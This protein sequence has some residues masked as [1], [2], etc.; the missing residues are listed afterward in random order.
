[1][2]KQGKITMLGIILLVLAI[3]FFFYIIDQLDQE[4][5]NTKELEKTVIK[6]EI[7]TK[8]L[9]IEEEFQRVFTWSYKSMN[10]RYSIK[11]YNET[12]EIYQQRGRERDY[13]LFASDPY[14]DYLIEDLVEKF[15]DFGKKYNLDEN[16]IP[17]FVVSFIQSLP[18]TSD[19]VTSGYDEYPRF[20]YETLYDGGG[21]CEDSAIL[22]AALLSEM[23]YGVVL[24]QF[25]DHMGLGVKCAEEV[26]GYRYEYN[27]YDYCYLETT[28]EN[29]DVGKLPEEYINEKAIVIP[30]YKRPYLD[31][32][33][34]G[35]IK[36]NYYNAYSTLN[37]TIYNLGSETAK[38]VRIYVALQTKDE[39][40]V[41]DDYTSEFL[42]IK[43]EAGYNYYV[44]NLKSPVGE[45]FRIYIVAY[46]D[47]IVSEEVVSEWVTWK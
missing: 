21:D 9:Q 31:I 44:T 16:E 10:P 30:V 27:G 14:D 47:N 36:Q 40:K 34:E 18:Y 29:W 32:K 8:I 12:Y 33:F 20:P 15:A 37:V 25:K 22:G 6:E 1:M 46:G 26:E 13:D 7:D 4:E 23:N 11:F 42:E 38:N 17:Y 24:I 35:N 19:N 43:P 3:I 41:W 45:D 39:S 28:G 2:N 5:Q